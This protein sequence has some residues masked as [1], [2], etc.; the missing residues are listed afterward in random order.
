MV[1]KSEKF[2]WFVRLGYFSRAVFYILIGFLALTAGSADTGPEGV[3]R[4]VQDF[5]AGTALLWIVAI[6]LLSYALFRM[7]SPLFDIEHEGSDRKGIAVRIG[8]A[9]SAIGHLVLAYSAVRLATGNGSGGG[10][11]AQ[12]AAA[13][14]LSVQFGSFVLG[15]LGVAFIATG[16]FQAKKAYSGE[17]MH[18]I[19]ASA[20]DATRW[21]GGAGFAARAVVFVVIG[22]SLIHSAW[23]SSSAQVMSLGSAISSLHDEGILFTLVAAGLILFGLFSL[24]LARYRI[25]PDLGA[26]GTVP[27]FRL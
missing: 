1:D 6:G 26:G 16:L 17:F 25:V 5:P 15:L 13:G 24:V 20:P 21:L 22:W 9:G 8:H 11:T 19:S 18:R 12:Q 27:T 10:D 4:T 7:C 2:R 14:V 3:F 23:I